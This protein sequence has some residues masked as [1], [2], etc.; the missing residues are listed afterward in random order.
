MPVMNDAILHDRIEELHLWAVQQGLVGARGSAIFEG[1]CARLAA[2][3]VPLWRTF[4]GMRTMH[5]QWGGYVFLWEYGAAVQPV[6]MERGDAYE[7]ALQSSPFGYLIETARASFAG[8]HKTLFM[9]R[10]LS[11]GNAPYDFV[12]LDELAAAGGTDYLAVIV[13]FRPAADPSSEHGLGFS[14]ATNRPGGFSEADIQLIR[15]VLPAVSL[16]IMCDASHTVASGLLTAYL[17]HDAGRRVHAGAVE[18]GSVEAMR[19][20]LWYADIRGFTA[21]ADALPGANLIEMLNDVFEALTAALRARGGQVLKF[22]GDG[23][24]ATFDLA[25]GEQ[26]TCRRALDAA[27]AA[28]AAVDAVDAS[29]I[30][31]GKPGVIVD[32][33]LHLGEVMYGNVGAI[34][35]LDFTIIGPAVNEVARLEPLCQPLGRKVLVSAAL[36]EAANEPERLVSLGRHALRGVSEPHEVYGLRL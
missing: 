22:I 24:L 29:H 34:D 26:A 9:R 7:H 10:R 25:D 35:R 33:A 11:P 23:M 3:G 14:F 5:P 8:Q 4:A 18:R 2:A 15:A 31:A 20:V 13:P 12:V 17:G 30:A 19:A 1:F 16:A 21:M 27:R 32:L 6:W 28:M 36:A